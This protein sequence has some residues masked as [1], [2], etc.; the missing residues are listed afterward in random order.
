[1]SFSTFL[2][3]VEIKTKLA[4]LFP[5]L[6]GVLFSISY[7]KQIHWLD[8]LIFF[9]AMLVFDMA[10]TAI[11]N[12]VDFKKAKSQRYKYEENIIGQ[13]RLSLPLVRGLIYGM[14]IVTIISG[15]FLAIRSGWPFMLIGAAC[16]LIGIFYTYGPIPLSRMPLG[17]LFSGFTMGLGI[18]LLV[19]CINVKSQ[20]PF[21]LQI[22]FATDTFQLG[23]QITSIL[24]IILAALPL[25]SS[26]ANVM[27]AN[28][29]RDLDNDIKNHRYTLVYYIG[30]PSGI[31]LFTFL[32]IVGYLTVV[33]G[34]IVG[35]YHWPVLFIFGSLQ[36]IWKNSQQFKQTLPHPKSFGYAI[37]N[38]VY[39]NISYAVGLLL[40]ICLYH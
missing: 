13:L 28:N 9:C 15:L 38:L 4:S 2:Q 14:I 1:M 19:I 40:S 26:I 8:T 16:C 37:K 6:I 21:Y 33:I 39:M 31:S 24:A 18:F 25:V 5:F 17:E 32:S 12:Y 22:N 11:N 23:G 27:L 29:L 20:P 7:F 36:T 10:T 30:R 35:I 3:L 34:L